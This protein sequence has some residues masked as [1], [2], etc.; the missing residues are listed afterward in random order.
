MVTG[1]KGRCY[2]DKLKEV[3]L[4]S[5]EDRRERGDMIQ[6]FKIIQGLDNVEVGTWFT[7]ASERDREG[8]TTTR[9]SQDTTRLEEGT[10]KLDLRRNFFSQRV[11]PIWNSLPQSTRQ[12]S[13]V[14][15]FKAAYDGTVLRQPGLP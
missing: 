15:S 5:L 3:G 13:S 1:L 12:K 10:S 8:A 4:T 9:H 6:T 2:E 11:P 14:L 7:L